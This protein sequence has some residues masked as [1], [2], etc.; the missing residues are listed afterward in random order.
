MLDTRATE[1][2]TL[3]IRVHATA[4]YTNALLACSKYE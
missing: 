4:A 1:T 3:D 2:N